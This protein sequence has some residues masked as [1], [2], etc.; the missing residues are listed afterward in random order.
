VLMVGGVNLF[1]IQNM[2]NAD[3]SIFLC[4]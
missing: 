3:P 4:F 1:E 2:Q